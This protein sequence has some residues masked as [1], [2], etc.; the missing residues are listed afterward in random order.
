MG[1]PF[2]IGQFQW[3]LV[4]NQGIW[5]SVTV[6]Y[7]FFMVP[8][9][10]CMTEGLNTWVSD[11]TT[12]RLWF[13]FLESEWYLLNLCT[14]SGLP[15][16]KWSMGSLQIISATMHNSCY[17]IL[18]L[19]MYIYIVICISYSQTNLT[20]PCLDRCPMRLSLWRSAVWPGF[21]LT[22]LF[23]RRDGQ[24]YHTDVAC[25]N[26]GCGGNPNVHHM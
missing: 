22:V 23:A 16:S 15:L 19:V 17:S 12:C 5:G 18:F 25:Q 11:T 14:P 21:Y 26:S 10:W 13:A 8:E 9:Q 24:R 2:F 6:A 1:I 3:P 20:Y 7:A 4:T